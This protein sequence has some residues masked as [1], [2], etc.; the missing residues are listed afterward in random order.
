[1]MTSKE[2]LM[3]TR[4]GS[5]LYLAPEVMERFYS[6]K[7][8]IWSLGCVAFQMYQLENNFRLGGEPPNHDA[9]SRET[10][11][12]RTLSGMLEFKDSIWQLMPSGKF[13]YLP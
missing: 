2:Q 8:D 3:S 7:V 11:R 12:R 5:P 10:L 4:C 13:M 6:N 9:G 1:M